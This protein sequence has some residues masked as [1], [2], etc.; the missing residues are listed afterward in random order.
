MLALGLT[1]AGCSF[2]SGYNP[3]YLP[4]QAMALGISGKSLVVLDTVDANW[5]IK[6][7]PTSFTGSATSLTVPMGE[8]TRQI[9]LKVFGSAFKD[10]ADFR[11]ASGDTSGYR[12]VIKPKVNKFTYAYNQL[13]NLGF[14]ITP[15]V[16]LELH[17]TLIGPDGKTL[18][19][20][21]YKSGLTEGDTYVISGQPAE[22]VSQILHQTLFKLMTDAALDAKKLLG[23]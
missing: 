8:I 6:S 3:S 15:Q 4:A 17:V 9:A 7:S 22:K 5:T 2:N 12:L 18:L 20:K 23:A 1:L 13:K 14:A 19:D 10:G 11:N 21:D 16:D